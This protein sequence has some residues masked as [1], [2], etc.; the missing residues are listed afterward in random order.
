MTNLFLESGF[1]S[2]NKHGESISGDFYTTI[3]GKDSNFNIKD[4]RYH[5]G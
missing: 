5:D 1:A 2:F 3:K 4:I